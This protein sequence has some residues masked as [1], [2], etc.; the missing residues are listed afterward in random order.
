MAVALTKIE[1]RP[2]GTI[3]GTI[4]W[5]SDP[6]LA[7]FTTDGITDAETCTLSNWTGPLPEQVYCVPNT[8]NEGFSCEYALSGADLVL[9]FQG[10]A[11][12][13]AWVGIKR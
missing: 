8:T 5:E 13:G 3:G 11:S 1:G 10:A 9:T 4:K 2:T 6:S 12:S 7:W